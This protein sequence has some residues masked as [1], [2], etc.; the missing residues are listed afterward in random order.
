MKK[1][2]KN[3]FSWPF[4]KRRQTW[5]AE[6]DRLMDRAA[7]A[8]EDIECRDNKDREVR[9]RK[10]AAAMYEHAAEYYRRAGLGLAAKNCLMN[11]S[12]EWELAGSTDAADRCEIAG[13]HID[14]YWGGDDDD[15]A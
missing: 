5:I 7:D 14:P 3:D 4:S 8:I 13:D 12:I 10:K 6:G 11:A 9:D 2:V 1:K 15:C